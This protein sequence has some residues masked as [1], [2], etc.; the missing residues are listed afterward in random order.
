[1]SVIVWRDYIY[2]NVDVSTAV[3]P[4]VVCVVDVDGSFDD[5]RAADAGRLC[6]HCHCSQV[7]SGCCIR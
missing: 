6:N 1:M 4:H 5:V 3:E 7:L 2:I